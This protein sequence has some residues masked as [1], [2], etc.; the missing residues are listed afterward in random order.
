MKL[1]IQIAN[2]GALGY[3]FVLVGKAGIGEPV[4]V[5]PG[6]TAMRA[7]ST[8]PPEADGVPVVTMV[9]T[10]AADVPAERLAEWLYGRLSSYRG[11]P[12]A[13]KA[14]TI[15]RQTIEFDNGE[16]TRVI[17]EAIATQSGDR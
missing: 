5:M 3:G 16:M 8:E 14:I 12:I 4:D 15:E 11:Q 10:V 9:L 6:V 1:T 2:R 17:Q 7:H 13:P